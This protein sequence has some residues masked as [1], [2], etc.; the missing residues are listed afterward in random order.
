MPYEITWKTEGIL[1]TFHGS[2]TGEDAIQ[3]NLDIYGDPRFDDLRYQIVDISKV[4]QFDIP[5]ES[6]ET[7]AAMDEAA[8]LNNPRLVVAVVAPE[9]EA[10]R[11]AEMYKSA[12]RSS[13]W[14]VEIFCSME[15]AREWVGLECG[16]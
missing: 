4:E 16:G 3:A 8:A 13:S 6:L 2:L 11:V 12:M 1:W 5:S 10:L 15:E 9:G 7:A 14:K